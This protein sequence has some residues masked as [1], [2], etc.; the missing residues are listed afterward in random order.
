VSNWNDSIIT[1]FRENNGVVGGPFA[2]AHLLLLTTTGAKSGEERVSPMMYFQ[3]GDDRI[4]AAS[5]AGAPTHPAWYH[6]LIANPDVRIA[7]SIDGGIEE[8]EATA[9]PLP[10]D[11]RGPRYAQIASTHPGFGEYQKKTDRVIPLVRLTRTK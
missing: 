2:G 6:N 3:D 7:A 11:E 9:T 10:E 4:V 1:E 8:Y 5:K